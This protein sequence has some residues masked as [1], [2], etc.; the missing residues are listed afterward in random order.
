MGRERLGGGGRGGRRRKK[1]RERKEEEEEEDEDEERSYGWSQPVS[2]SC[3]SW[4]PPCDRVTFR[5]ILPFSL[6]SVS[7]SGQ[8]VG[9]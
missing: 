2:S 9:H 4:L 3:R 6:A 7:P 5:H 8:H 1:G